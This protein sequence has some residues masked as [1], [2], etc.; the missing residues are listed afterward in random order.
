MCPATN[1]YLAMVGGL[2]FQARSVV[3][4]VLNLYQ[5]REDPASA[6]KAK[7]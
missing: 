3:L 6:V 5:L 2:K 1:A 4:K 7:E